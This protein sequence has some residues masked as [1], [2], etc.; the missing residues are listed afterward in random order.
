[1]PVAVGRGVVVVEVESAVDVV[2]NAYVGGGFVEYYDVLSVGI[3]TSD[4]GRGVEGDDVSSVAVSREGEGGAGAD[5]KHG[6]TKVD[7][8]LLVA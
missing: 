4:I 5:V 8:L 6:A 2:I 3:F 7:F 1:M